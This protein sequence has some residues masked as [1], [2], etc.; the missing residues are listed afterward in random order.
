MRNVDLFELVKRWMAEHP[1][2][3]ERVPTGAELVID[4]IEQVND[5]DMEPTA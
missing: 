3:A 2:D 1:D 5:G 4:S